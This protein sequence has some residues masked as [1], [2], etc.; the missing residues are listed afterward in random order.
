VK[1]ATPLLLSV[2]LLFGCGVY[3]FKGQGISG[4]KSIAVESF[5]NNTTEFGIR[6]AVTDAIVSKLLSDRTLA[7]TSP[8]GADAILSGVINSISDRA[9]TFSSDE[10]VSEYEVT[11]SISFKLAKPGGSEPIWEGEITGVGAYPYKT[12]SPE[13]RKEGITKALDKIVQDLINRLTSDW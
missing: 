5:D 4:I 9:L 3:S 2:F 13:E 8:R 7:V 6:E 12:G 1:R 11:I 10:S